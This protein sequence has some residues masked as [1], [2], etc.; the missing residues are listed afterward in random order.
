[1]TECKG[2]GWKAGGEA[3]EP[4]IPKESP[5]ETP[6]RPVNDSIDQRIF[7]GQCLNATF[8]WAIEKDVDLKTGPPE[9][10]N[11]VFNSFWAFG[12]AKLLEKFG[13]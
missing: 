13:K 9:A 7:F 1:M 2:C 11:A 3:V 5:S 4:S 10:L 6:E 8:N 12:Q